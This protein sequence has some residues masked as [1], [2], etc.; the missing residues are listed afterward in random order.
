MHGLRGR[1]CAVFVALAPL[2]GCSLMGLDDFGAKPCVRNDDC[3][4]AKEQLWPNACGPAVCNVQTGLCEWHEPQETCNGK[5]DDC[6]GLIDEGLTLPAQQASAAVGDE[7]AVVSYAMA[8]TSEP[9]QTYVA[10]S[11]SDR[12]AVG[13]TLGADSSMYELEYDSLLA[14]NDCPKVLEPRLPRT[15]GAMKC[16]FA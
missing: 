16:N 2:L 10:V 1:V 15:T 11:T 7:R 5:D 13:L 8:S 12:S 3:A 9:A 4:R 14:P 6:D